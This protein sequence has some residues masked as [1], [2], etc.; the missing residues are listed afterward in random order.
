MGT[1]LCTGIAMDGEPLPTMATSTCGAEYM[2][3]SLAVKELIWIYMLLKTMG[4]NVEKPCI[5][6]EDNR[7][8]IKVAENASAM[9][10]SKQSTF[11]T[12]SCVNMSTM[13]LLSLKLS[14]P[15]ISW[16]TL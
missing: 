4:V 12:T 1:S 9:R 7:S 10:R 11:V 5:V 13:G 15:K 14:A 16:Q 2:A 3:L 8:C 6:Y